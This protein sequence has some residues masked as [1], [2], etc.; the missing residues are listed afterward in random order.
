MKLLV[1]LLSAVSYTDFRGTLCDQITEWRTGHTDVGA[2]WVTFPKAATMFQTV[3]TYNK[4][5]Y[6]CNSHCILKWQFCASDTEK[7]R[8]VRAGLTVQTSD[9][10]QIDMM[11]KPQH[12]QLQCKAMWK[13]THS[14]VL[15]LARVCACAHVWLRKSVIQLHLV[16]KLVVA[17]TSF[18]KLIKSNQDN[19]IN[20]RSREKK[21]TNS[22]IYLSQNPDAACA[23]AVLASYSSAGNRRV[24]HPPPAS[25]GVF[26]C[27]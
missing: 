15:Q 9:G 12:K 26:T 7:L 3:T 4:H 22:C 10:R 24:H 6:K 8:F 19:Q 11:W 17:E 1:K 20:W 27:A 13:A 21:K 14:L 25:F 5:F 16:Q 2:F 23:V 18:G